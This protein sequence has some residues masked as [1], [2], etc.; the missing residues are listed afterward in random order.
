MQLIF[1]EYNACVINNELGIYQKWF[2]KAATVAAGIGSLQLKKG[3]HYKKK[4]KRTRKIPTQFPMEKNTQRKS[5]QEIL[6][7][8][9]LM[10][11]TKAEQFIF[12][13]NKTFIFLKKIN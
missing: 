1:Y 3:K 5:Y 9:H 8:L 13:K 6:D 12:L 2:F 4:T 11:V 10:T 7:F